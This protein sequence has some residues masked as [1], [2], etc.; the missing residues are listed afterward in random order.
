MSNGPG[1]FFAVVFKYNL[2]SFQDIFIKVM[3][4]INP[5]YVLLY[6]KNNLSVALKFL[7]E[8]T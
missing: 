8:S 7:A 3:L 1:I 6:F 2:L 4:S 5:W